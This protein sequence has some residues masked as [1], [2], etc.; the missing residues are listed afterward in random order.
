MNASD[1]KC[2][3]TIVKV[4][5]EEVLSIRH[6]AGLKDTLVKALYSGD[7]VILNLS[8]CS[9]VD[10]SCIQLIC[11]AH[12]TALKMNKVIELGDTLPDTIAK[13]VEDAGYLHHKDCQSNV[14]RT[15]LWLRR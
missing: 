2:P 12:R 1:M 6:A 13:A 15:C 14:S 8:E 7:H 5:P 10:L 4:T 9:C 11:S 3:D